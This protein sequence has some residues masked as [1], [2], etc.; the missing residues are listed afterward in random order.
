VLVGDLHGLLALVRL[1]ADEHLVEHDAERVDV[2]AGV[3]GAAGDE[4]GAR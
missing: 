1:L 4:L 3:G 2:A